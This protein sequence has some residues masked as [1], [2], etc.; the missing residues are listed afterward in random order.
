M[1][2]G[3]CK[4]TMATMLKVESKSIISLCN[5]GAPKFIHFYKK[6]TNDK[7]H[8]MKSEILLISQLPDMYCYARTIKR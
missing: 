3:N 4:I 5:P 1:I 6:H 7:N 2:K 8:G